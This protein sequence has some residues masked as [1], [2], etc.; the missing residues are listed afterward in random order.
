MNGEPIS[1]SP[2][3]QNFTPHGSSP[4]VSR[5]ARIAAKRAAML[6]LLS[7]VPRPYSLPSFCTGSNGGVFQR[8]SGSSGC[9][10]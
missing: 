6:P 4:L 8:S 10:S 7:N 9:T 1:S 5:Q 2:S 3:M